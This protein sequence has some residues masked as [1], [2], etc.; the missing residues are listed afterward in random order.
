MKTI[1]FF[2]TKPYEKSYFEKAN[3]K[4]GFTIHYLDVRLN[5]ETAFLGRGAEAACAFV[6]DRID[7]PAAEELEKAG[8][9]IL[10]MRCAGFN[11]VD[12]KALWKKIPVV[13]V[14]AY[15]PYSI[16]EHAV[17][18][19]LCMTRSIH[20]AYNRVREGNFL[21]NGL[22]GRD[23]HGKTAGIVGTGKIGKITAAILKGFGM[24]IAAYD[25][26]P[27]ISW[28]AST[29]AQYLCLEDLCARADVISLHS[30]LTPETF[31]M[32]NEKNL[33]LMKSDA[34]LIN[35]G[36]GALID[37]KALVNAL[38]H[39]KIGG[40]G[41]DVYEE[42]E[43]YFFE[44]RSG[45]AVEDDIL[46]RL[47]TFPNVIITGH[48]AFLTDEALGAIAQTTLENIYQYFTTGALP[49]EVSWQG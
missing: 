27:D 17:A 31:H 47:L 5:Q 24:E 39:R 43:Y 33:A 28:A 34:V 42:E 10:A 2:D 48:Q 41:L 25:K 22:T 38:K 3:E 29:G 49:N 23:L 40:A 13:R 36:R 16:A 26:F 6:N 35:T 19:L 32:I 20:K 44:D 37:T 1:A 8:M 9:K 12:L 18:L 45:E 15:S 4:Y 46:A 30:P 7:A 21:L 11:N 14:P